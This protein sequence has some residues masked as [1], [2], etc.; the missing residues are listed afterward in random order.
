L[1]AIVS[2]VVAL[3][4]L[5]PNVT[6]RAVAADQGI[7]EIRIKDHRE[8]IGDFSR[9]ILQLQQ[10]SISPKAGLASWKVAWRDLPPSVPAIDL[11]KYTGKESVSVF[12]GA[13][14]AGAFDAVQV[15]LTSVEG[16]LKKNQRPA[17]VKNALTPIQLAFSVQPKG[18]T[19]IVLDLVVLDLSD[20]PPRGYELGIKGYEV[21]TNGKLTARIPPG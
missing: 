7:L 3:F 16:V 9:L 1:S 2:L 8:A 19:I 10:L 12:K 13:V 5:L 11:T 6:E 20:H 17:K 15:K 4:S 21:Y 14:A 18:E